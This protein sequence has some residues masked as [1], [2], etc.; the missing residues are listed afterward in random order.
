MSGPPQCF[1]FLKTGHQAFQCKENPTCTKCGG[2]H[3]SQDCK[4]LSYTPSIRRCVQCINQEKPTNQQVDLYDEKYRHSALSQKCP[5]HQ[6]EIQD[7]TPQPRINGKY[8]STISA[9]NSELT[10]TALLLQE[11]WVN[12]QNWHRITPTTN[13]RTKDEKPQTCISINKQIPYH[14]IVNH[15]QERNLLT[16]ITLL[17]VSNSLYCPCTTHPPLSQQST[18]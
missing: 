5:I 3:H 11:P 4:D 1:N 8:D 12:P 9:L 7:L 14:Q 17:G 13:P 6:R 2:T 10:Y 15:P 16:T 18:S